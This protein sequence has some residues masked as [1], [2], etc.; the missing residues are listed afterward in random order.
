MKLGLS[1]WLFW[2]IMWL[3]ILING[4]DIPDFFRSE[5]RT[6][7]FALITLGVGPFFFGKE[8]LIARRYLLNILNLELL[9]ITILSFLGY[10]LRFLPMDGQ[11][12]YLGCTPHSMILGVVSGLSALICLHELLHRTNTSRRR[13]CWCCCFIAC[14]IVSMLAASRISLGSLCCAALAYVGV[15]NKGNYGKGVGFLLML[16]IVGGIALQF[17][18]DVT[19]GLQTKM[20]YSQDDG[21]IFS[22]RTMIW[23]ARLDEI[24]ESPIWGIG[25]HTVRDDYYL[26]YGLPGNG[27]VEPGNAWLY[28]FSS[29]GIFS[30]LIFAYL[31]ISPVIYFG[32]HSK[33][34]TD[35]VLLFSLLLF[36]AIYMNA[37]AHI[38]AA[39][40]ITCLYGW[41]LVAIAH[42]Q[43]EESISIPTLRILPAL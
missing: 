20:Q 24:K 26:M 8:C 23:Q 30:F 38:T 14:T 13:W 2:C 34:G 15:T 7:A 5:Q 16:G 18:G 25:A 43:K 17:S 42:D 22:S 19:A 12:F 28:V 1:M 21:N 10:V 3:S 40:D 29:M 33:A 9:T 41:L 37:E 31:M 4:N 35:G 11:G 39:G 32:F 27:Q 6:I 36:M